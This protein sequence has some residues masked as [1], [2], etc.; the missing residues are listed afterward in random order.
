MSYA[1]LI[2]LILSILLYS[3]LALAFLGWGKAFI[4][5]T[6]RNTSSREN[7]PISF[8][9]WSGW[10]FALLLLQVIH[11]FTPINVFSVSPIILLG[12]IF[13]I[14]FRVHDTKTS[15]KIPSNGS[16]A[17]CS[18]YAW[19]TSI[20]GF[21]LVTCWIASRAMIPPTNYDSGLY[22]L[23]AIRWINEYPIVPG[24]GNLHGRLAFNSSFF[25]YVAALN[26][27]PY[28]GNGRSIANSFLMLLTFATLS[29]LLLPFLRRPSFI[30]QSS[31]IQWAIP[32]FCLPYIAYWT[33]SSDGIPSPSPDLTSSLL[34]VVIF[35][36]FLRIST[37]FF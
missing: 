31:P 14:F 1:H 8:V 10:A 26:L 20:F 34:Q 15:Q 32:L 9:I 18:R 23:S 7:T 13:S 35:I 36:I 29:E 28:F 19:M 16:T 37:L 30:F 33:L 2:A 27:Y 4:I 21:I 22:H 11:F 25:T 5:F 24:L 6:S 12:V 3:L 17:R